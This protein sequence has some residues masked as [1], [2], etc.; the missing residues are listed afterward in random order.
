M[1]KIISMYNRSQVFKFDTSHN[2]R[3]MHTGIRF[4]ILDSYKD[5]AKK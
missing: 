3:T 5:T 4:Y 1:M 2:N